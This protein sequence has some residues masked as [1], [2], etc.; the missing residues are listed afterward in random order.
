MS[1]A[2]A[3]TPPPTAPPQREAAAPMADTA[4]L[5]QWQLIRMG[6]A[7]HWLA[8]ASLHLLVLPR[9]HIGTLRDLTPADDALI[10]HL[11]RVASDVARANGHNDFRVV[12]NC[13]AGAGQSVFHLHLHVLAG[14]T[15]A[16]PPG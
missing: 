10:G 3:P 14:R 11:H 13:G 2:V 1:A 5:S 7:K 15:L 12:V 6:F 8:V 4:S 9:Q 16:W